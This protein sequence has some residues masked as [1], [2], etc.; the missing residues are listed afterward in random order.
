MSDL[1]L[2]FPQHDYIQ[3]KGPDWPDYEDFLKGDLGQTSDIQNEITGFLE[4]FKKDGVKFPIRT[5]TS[6]QSKWTWSTIYLNQLSTASCHR[7]NPVPFSL[8]DFDNFHNLPK[9]LQDRQLML[10]G[11]WPTGGCEYCKNIEDAGG[12]SDRQHNLEIRNLTPPELEIDATAISVTPRILEIFAQNT[13]NLMCTY[14]NSNLSSKIEQENNK[15][16]NFDYQGVNIPVTSVPTITK[17]Y[18]E[19][20]MSWLEKNILILK[21]LHLLGGETLIQHE[22]M[23]RVLNIIEHNPNPDLQF[24]IFSNL[25]VPNKAWDLY[26]PRIQDLQNRKHIQVFDLTASIDCWGEEAQYARSGLNLDK[27]EERFAWAAEQDESWLRLN[28]NQT[29]T[30][31]TMRTMP[32]LIEKLAYYARNR[33]IGH[34][35]QFYTGPQMF[36]HPNVYAYDFWAKTF[37]QIFSVM[38]S[39]TN[40]QLEAIDRMKGIQKYLQVFTQHNI[41][42]ISKLHVY[43]DELDRRRGTDWRSI[44]PYLCIG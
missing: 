17:E 40:N 25:N 7:V 41:K 30:C 22:L 43:L 8:E 10:R 20:F 35:F 29:M 27:F 39:H 19:K 3:L 36:Q 6:C 18:F 44:F 24:C 34:Y 38:P 11:E 28:I 14:C 26:I 32:D 15:F 16:G 4:M 12:W 9:K 42:E 2:Y 23:S 13:C 1:S 5:K 33:H 37:D 21:R 31:L